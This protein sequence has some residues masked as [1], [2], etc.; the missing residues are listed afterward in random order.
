MRFSKLWLSSALPVISILMISCGKATDNAA[1]P[2]PTPQPSSDVDASYHG[3][4]WVTLPGE[5]P[6]VGQWFTIEVS[7]HENKP[8]TPSSTNQ[9]TITTDDGDRVSYKPPSFKLQAGKRALVRVKINKPGAG[10][11]PIALYAEEGY[12]PYLNEVEV[13]FQGHL[14]VTHSTLL[15][16]ND[17]AAVTIGIVDNNDKSLPVDV[18]LEMQIQAVDALL[19][20]GTLGPTKEAIWTDHVT[21]PINA[22]A[23]SSPQFQIKSTNPK[24]GEVHILATLNLLGNGG[25]VAQDS[26]SFPVNPA[27]WLPIILAIL[28]SLLYGAYNFVQSPK[29]RWQDI[30]LQLAASIIGGVI[31]YLFT[32]FDL[33][34]IKLDPNVLKTYPLLGF[35]FSYVGIE[36]LL[37]KRFRSG[38]KTGEH[39]EENQNAAAEAAGK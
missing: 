17:P 37:S 11:A 22:G 4:I 2:Q 3:A 24:G 18:T 26:F 35:L 5:R 33:L 13:G 30:L 15:A 10:I 1:Q 29:S 21:L 23:R 14:K 28:G 16:Y 6:I 9:I 25:V 19:S 12:L 7:L 20:D 39:A 8:N 38:P 32:G 31:A 36:I 27:V 34:G